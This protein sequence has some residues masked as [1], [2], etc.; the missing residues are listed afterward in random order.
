MIHCFSDLNENHES[1]S[2]ENK[3]DPKQEIESKTH[4]QT[5]LL[6]IQYAKDR[7]ALEF[8]QWGNTN[9]LLIRLAADFLKAE[10]KPGYS[11]IMTSKSWVMLTQ[12]FNIQLK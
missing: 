11:G 1:S 4:I 3:I 8:S 2:L 10:L 5:H 6:K 12:Q 7:R 9:Y